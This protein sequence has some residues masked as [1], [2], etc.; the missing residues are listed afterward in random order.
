[1]SFE[2][3][4][5][6]SNKNVGNIGR[7]TRAQSSAIASKRKIENVSPPAIEAKEKKVKIKAP[8]ASAAVEEV[9]VDKSK[10]IEEVV[11][12]EGDSIEIEPRSPPSPPATRPAK[13]KGKSNADKVPVQI[14]ELKN[15]QDRE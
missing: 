13:E 15:E 11:E 1:M 5:E 14:I 2:N 10:E 6:R 4:L 9:V 8:D 7:V 3:D 12:S